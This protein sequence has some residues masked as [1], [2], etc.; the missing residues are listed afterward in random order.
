MCGIAGYFG[1]KEISKK[2]I[3]FALNLMKNRGPDAQNYKVIKNKKKN[4][5]LLHSRLSIIDL[6]ERSNQPFETEKSILIFNGEIYNYLEL[7]KNL[8]GKYYFKTNSDTEVVLACYEIYGEKCFS[9]FDGMWSIVIFDKLKQKLIF[10]RDRFGEKPL[11]YYKDNKG[12]FFASEIKI[13]SKLSKKKFKINIPKVKTF[14]QFGY[15]SIFKNNETFFKKVLSFKQSNFY[16][17][18][19]KSFKNKSYYKINVKDHKQQTQQIS[20]NLRK[21]WT[22]A[23]SKCLR[24]DVPVALC[25]SGGIDSSLIAA[26]SKKILQKKLEC[27]SI[28]DNGDKRYD[29]TDNIILLQKKLNLKVNFVNI[30]NKFSFSRL[31]NQIKFQ[32]APVFTIS[33]YIQNFL[34]QQISKK[35]FKVVLSGIAADEIFGGYYDHQLM[36]FLEVFKNKILFRKHYKS[37][38]KDVLPNIRNKYFKDHLLFIKNKNKRSYIYDHN[39]ELSKFFYKPEKNNFSEKKYSRSLLK[40]RMINEIYSETVPV[41]THSEDLNFMQYSIENRSPYLY[42]S[43]VN[44]C[45]QISRSLI[46]QNGYTKYFLREIGKKIIPNEIR[47]DKRKRGFNASIY[48]LANLESKCFKKFIKKKSV[49]DKIVN[50]NLLLKEIEK[51]NN[52]NYISKFIFSYISC[53]LFLEV[54]Q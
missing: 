31:K 14:L 38:Q 41:M 23:L 45:F 6:H 32:D 43:I 21:I 42:P 8:K 7:R 28:V 50:K 46:M 17:H 5:Y 2:T 9:F 10:S 27:F 20:S 3:N 18:N 1:T 34:A 33:H 26:Y 52:E 22:D 39:K 24:S 4:L 35:N 40:N 13:L 25:L 12:I 54:N 30:K 19:G 53:K 49:L 51:K 44:N 48:T 36:Y 16:I 47:L 37:W 15:K 11:Y 29:E